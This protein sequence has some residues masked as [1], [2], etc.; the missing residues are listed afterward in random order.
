MTDVLLATSRDTPPEIVTPLAAALS[1]RDLQVKTVDLGRVGET[2]SRLG[3]VVQALIGEVEAGRLLRELAA[4]QPRVAVALD[5]GALAALVLARDRRVA[6]TPAVGVVP[7]LAPGRRWAVNADRFAVIDDEAAVALSDLGVDGARVVVIGPIVPRAIHEAAA[8]PRGAIRR[9]Y[10]LPEAG[11]VALVDCR[12]FE[13]E[14]LAQVTLQMSLLSRAAHV[15]FDA[16]GDAEAAAQVRRQ[17][18]GLGIKGKL[19]GETPNAPRLWRAADL[20]VA[21]PT[22]RALHAA[23]ALGAVVIAVEPEGERQ[24][25][26]A[27]ALVERGLGLVA[28]K[29][30][31]VSGAVDAALGKRQV[32]PAGADGA[33]EAAELVAQVAAHKDEVL[34][35]TFASAAGPDE[36]VEAAGDLED[37]GDLGFGD[38]APAPPPR[39]SAAEE[40][41]RKELAD[42]RAEAE[43]WERRRALAEAQGDRALAAQAAREADRKRARMHEALESLKRMAARGGAAAPPEDPL[44]ALRRKARATPAE[45]APKSLDDELAALKSK[46]RTGP[47]TGKGR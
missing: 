29:V 9:E 27:R 21:R 46:M 19:F 47:G 20:V 39:V 16:G 26:D 25:A 5:P 42:A 14:A 4:S 43:R 22:S 44:E 40:R 2:G 31:F 30:V 18:P 35:E 32:S 3:R 11:P 34:A 36:P 1:A 10:K 8:E 23:R 12:G 28:E 7:D 24:L 41:L 15:L 33:A 45:P 37:L 6:A 13:L 38:D 17:V